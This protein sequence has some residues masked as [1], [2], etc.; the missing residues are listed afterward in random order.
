MTEQSESGQQ[1]GTISHFFSKI[2]VG[3]IELTDSLRVGETIR[4]LGHTTD[5]VMTVESMQIENSQVE[6]A[7]PGDSVGLKVPDHVREGD[8]VYRV[9]S[10]R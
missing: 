2:S 10:A 7:K 4:I 3:V 6:Q 9:E 5:L 1:I 8:H